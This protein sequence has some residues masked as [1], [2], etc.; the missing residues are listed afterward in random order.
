MVNG[1]PGVVHR[2][3]TWSIVLSILMMIAGALAILTPAVTGIGVMMLLGWLL[4]GSGVLHLVFAWR[5]GHASA[6]IWEILL[7]IL[8]GGIGFY[9]IGQPLAGLA[10]VTF[11]IAGYLLLKGVLEFVVWMQLRRLPGTRWLLFDGIL[12]FV[13]AAM[14]WSAFPASSLWVVG[15]LVGVSMLSSG[16]TRLQLS[17]A[18]RRLVS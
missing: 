15:T 3:T 8:Y 11:A 7:G 4:I 18:A 17:L 16:M 5:G 2:A 12:T 10:S 14:I 13:L 9:I 6:V 1:L